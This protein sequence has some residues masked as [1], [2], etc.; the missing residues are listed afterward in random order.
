MVGGVGSDEPRPVGDVQSDI[1]GDS[2]VGFGV[3]GGSGLMEW[4]PLSGVFVSVVFVYFRGGVGVVD[5][6]GCVVYCHFR[7]DII[8]VHSNVNPVGEIRDC[9]CD[10]DQ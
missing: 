2:V 4:F 7:G 10:G 9:Q 3:D 6:S 8:D 1:V 5:G